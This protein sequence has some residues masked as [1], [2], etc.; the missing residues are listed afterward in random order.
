MK[1]DRNHKEV[2]ELLDQLQSQ[3]YNIGKVSSFVGVANVQYLRNELYNRGWNS[4][5]A[6]DGKTVILFQVDQNA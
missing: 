6:E 4:K 3:Y 2:T 1:L 5:L